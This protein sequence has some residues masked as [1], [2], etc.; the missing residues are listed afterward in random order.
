MNLVFQPYANR[1][2]RYLKSKHPSV[3]VVYFAN[4]GSV[5]LHAQTDMCVDAL[6]VDWKLSMLRARQVRVRLGLG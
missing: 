3:P 1:I 2:A 6:S 5:Y 4:G